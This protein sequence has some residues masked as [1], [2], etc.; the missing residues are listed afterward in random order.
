[1]TTLKCQLSKRLR[2]SFSV[3]LLAFLPVLGFAQMGDVGVGLQFGS[4]SGVTLRFNSQ[5]DLS[6]EMLAAWDSF[7]ESYFL[8]VHA[9]LEQPLGNSPFNLIYGV[10]GFIGGERQRNTVDKGNVVILGGSVNGG[11]NVYVDRF[12]IYGQITPRLSVISRFFLA[13]GGGIGVR[14]YF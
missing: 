9:L 2:A 4:P 11:I 8:N 12:E 13:V 7:R 1:M 3:L 5:G 14:Y 6:Y 10:G